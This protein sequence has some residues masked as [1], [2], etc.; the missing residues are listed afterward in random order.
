MIGWIAAYLAFS[1]C[2]SLCV[3][4]VIAWGGVDHE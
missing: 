4:R 3:A 1:A 2:F